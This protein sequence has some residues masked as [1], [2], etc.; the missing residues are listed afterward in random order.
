MNHPTVSRKRFLQLYTKGPHG[1]SLMHHAKKGGEEALAV[2]E[3][4][5]G[6][7]IGQ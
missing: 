2:V 7:G 6:Q 5:E 1:L 3:W 4:L